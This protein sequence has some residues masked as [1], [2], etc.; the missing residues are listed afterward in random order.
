ML[1]GFVNVADDFASRGAG[2]DDVVDTGAVL[3]LRMGN[4]FAFHLREVIGVQQYL[5]RV[6]QLLN[7]GVSI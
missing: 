3:R 5:E 6:R 1:L 4:V 7:I 2:L